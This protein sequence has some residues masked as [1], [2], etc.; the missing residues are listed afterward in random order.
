MFEDRTQPFDTAIGVGVAVT[1]FT[2]VTV[3]VSVGTPPTDGDYRWN[4]QIK[5][6]DILEQIVMKS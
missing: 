1:R 6:W 3:D 4:Q 2:P 5:R